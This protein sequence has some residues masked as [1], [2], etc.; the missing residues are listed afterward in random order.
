LENTLDKIHNL[1][2]RDITCD[3]GSFDVFDPEGEFTTLLGNVGYRSEFV[4]VAEVLV[5]AITTL[6]DLIYCIGS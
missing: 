4:S 5:V 6:W 1:L 3:C 2:Y